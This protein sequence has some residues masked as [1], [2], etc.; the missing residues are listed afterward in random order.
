VVRA[1]P[2]TVGSTAVDAAAAIHTDL[3]K[4]FIRAETVS[5][6]DLVTLGSMA[7]AR[8]AGRLRSE[9]KTYRVKDGDVIEVLFSR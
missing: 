3:A 8:K 6:E 7:E 2:F 4:G 9:G 1:G 5:Y